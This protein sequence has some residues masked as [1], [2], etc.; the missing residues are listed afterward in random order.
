ME[1]IFYKP[2]EAIEIKIFQNGLSSYTQKNCQVT[3]TDKGCR[4]YRPPNKTPSAD[5]STMWGGMRLIN[6]TTTSISHTYNPEIDNYFKLI[7]GHTYIIRFHVT[8][9]SSDAF[10]T[11]DWTNQMGWGGGGLSPTPSDIEKHG[12]PTNF[13][14]EEECFYKFTIND[15]ISKTCTT[16]YSYATQGNTYL[17]YTHF[18]VG[19]AYTNTGALGTDLYITNLRMYDITNN[20]KN[21]SI[22]KEGIILPAQVIEMPITQASIQNSGDLICNNFYEY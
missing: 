20:E 21:Y 6:A 8:G 7:Q 1:N 15:T 19:F 12:I 10:A 9:Q 4:I 22:T 17:S 11:F 14:G 5:G 18:G 13:E 3:L 2:N 16:T